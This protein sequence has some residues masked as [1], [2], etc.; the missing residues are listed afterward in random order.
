[1]MRA[2]SFCI[3][4]AISSLA[5]ADEA[6][7]ESF[8][9]ALSRV[10]YKTREIK[11]FEAYF[12]KYGREL[13]GLKKGESGTPVAHLGTAVAFLQ[14]LYLDPSKAAN[15]AAYKAQI[16]F[17]ERL[18]ICYQA[19]QTRLR[20]DNEMLLARATV[21]ETKREKLRELKN[22]IREPRVVISEDTGRNDQDI[23]LAEDPTLMDFKRGVANYVK[24]PSA[25]LWLSGARKNVPTSVH[26]PEQGEVSRRRP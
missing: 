7:Q 8:S 17:L 19:L 10:G 21:T 12:E 18:E 20:N 25:P 23:F 6:T 2:L 16:E 13:P 22:S 15:K 24:H 1:M 3:L 26:A 9:D 5:L 4:I 11:E 14:K